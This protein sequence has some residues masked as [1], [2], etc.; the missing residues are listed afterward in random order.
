MPDDVPSLRSTCHLLPLDLPSQFI[1]YPPGGGRFGVQDSPNT[2]CVRA[3]RPLLRQA[4]STNIDIQ[5]G[6]RVVRVEEVASTNKVVAYF[7]DGTSSTGDIVIGADGTW[8][9]GQSTHLHV[10]I[11]PIGFQNAH[12]QPLTRGLL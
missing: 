9:K 12:E 2:P 10:R 5:W 11:R 6:K 4:L 3:S 7:Q 1:V 8:S